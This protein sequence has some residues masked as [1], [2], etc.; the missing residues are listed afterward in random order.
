MFRVIQGTSARSKAL[1]TAAVPPL[2]GIISRA[3]LTKLERSLV[4]LNG[5][6]ERLLQKA[7]QAGVTSDEAFLEN[8]SFKNSFDCAA[9]DFV[10]TWMRDNPDKVSE[11]ALFLSSGGLA[12]KAKKAEVGAMS[13][14]TLA[15]S[16][17][18][19]K[20]VMTQLPD[21]PTSL[22]EA[23]VHGGSKC[24]ISQVWGDCINL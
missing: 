21:W 7:V 20:F 23:A 2:R 13:R 22:A 16:D 4:K 11:L 3:Y 12:G 5:M 10:D 17:L 19:K 18:P 8:S 9:K 15:I 6:K 14:G 1:P 24:Y